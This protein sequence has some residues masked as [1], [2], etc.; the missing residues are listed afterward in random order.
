MNTKLIAIAIAATSL[1]PAAHASSEGSVTFAFDYSSDELKSTEGR[2]E[3]MARLDE[4]IARQCRI[5]PQT[6]VLMRRA[7]DVACQK[8]ARTDALSKLDLPTDLATQN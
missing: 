8:T 1:I 3:L 7:I 5:E 2:R 6:T 4:T